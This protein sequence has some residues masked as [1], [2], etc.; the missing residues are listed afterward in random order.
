MKLYAAEKN[1]MN[2]TAVKV[3]ECYRTY[4]NFKFENFL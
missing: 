2:E 3:T 4:L 1:R